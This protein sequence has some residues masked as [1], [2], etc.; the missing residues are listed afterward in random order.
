M[1]VF[2]APSCPALPRGS[3]LVRKIPDP[4]LDRGMRRRGAADRAPAA[5]RFPDRAIPRYNLLLGMGGPGRLDP[6]HPADNRGAG[7]ALLGIGEK[8]GI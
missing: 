3:L 1:A 5:I 4:A 2:M 8:K 7:R 6:G